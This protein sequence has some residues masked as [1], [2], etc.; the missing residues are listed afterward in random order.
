MMRLSLSGRII[1]LQYRSCELGVPDF[2]RLAR[3]SGYDAVEL[4]ATQLPADTTLAEAERIHRL[5]GGLGLSI[6]CCI[7]AGVTADAAGLERLEQ[8]VDLA[9]A[10][11]CDC[12][13]VWIGDATWLRQAC[14]RIAPHGLSLVAQTHTGG[15]FETIASCLETLALIG[16]ANFGLQ[17]DPANL[18]EAEQEYGEEGVKQLGPYLR[19]LSV[20]SVRLAGPEAGEPRFGASRVPASRRDVGG[21]EAAEKGAE[22]QRSRGGGRERCVSSPRGDPGPGPGD[23]WEHAGRR[24]RRCQ[25][26]E[27][28]ALDYHSVFRGLR[29]IGFDGYVTVNEPKPMLMETPVFAKRMHDVLRAML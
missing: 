6:S 25:L 8:F 20:Q 24:Y 29:A 9:L 11:D 22:R 10:L 13:K 5:A 1:E 7:P 12:L 18:F 14:D 15:P 21:S 26:D 16:R 19:Q 27:P 23:G 3:E 17:Y 4:R 2:L 28:G